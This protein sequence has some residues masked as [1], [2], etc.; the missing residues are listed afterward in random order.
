MSQQEKD[1]EPR[2]IKPP[3]EFTLKEAIDLLREKGCTIKSHTNLFDEDDVFNP[4]TQY[5]FAWPGEEHTTWLS[6]WVIRRIGYH[7]YQ[8]NR[9]PPI[10]DIIEGESTDITDRRVLKSG[11]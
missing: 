8:G 9:C 3:E 6:S 10:D 5:F 11:L 7:V 4:S 2:N 1:L